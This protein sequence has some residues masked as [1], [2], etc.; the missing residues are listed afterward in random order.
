MLHDPI[1]SVFQD[2]FPGMFDFWTRT[3][4][5]KWDCLPARKEAA[6]KIATNGLKTILGRPHDLWVGKDKNGNTVYRIDLV[7]TPFAK[8]QIK[9]KLGEEF[10]EVSIGG[11]A[12]GDKIVET[13]LEKKAED[14]DA[15]LKNLYRGISRK[16]FYLKL[17]LKNLV[18]EECE[19]DIDVENIK[20]KA[21]DGI[22]QLTIPT[23]K[24]K[25]EEPELTLIP[26]L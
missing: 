4:P 21:E 25:V 7:Y 8:D 15:N 6:N 12:D 10:L 5:G 9:V 24:R 2:I 3:I 23:K 14:K 17:S 16:A 18:D 22:L 20:A 19:E 13:E 26:V 11:Y 1:D